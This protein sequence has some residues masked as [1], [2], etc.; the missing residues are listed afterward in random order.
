MIKSDVVNELHKPARKKFPRRRTI[1]K[2]LDDLWQIDLAEMRPYSKQNSGHN[3]I[4]VVI[5][6]FS[7]MLWTRPLK[8]KTANMVESAVKHVF[9]SSGRKPQNLQSD[10]GKEFYNAKF[11]SLMKVNN[12]NHYST[13]STT[14]AA[15]A[16][17]VIRT[18]KEKLYKK[19]S[20]QGSYNW[21]NILDQVTYEYNNTKHS[22]IKMK[23][24]NVTKKVEK[25]LLN[26]VYSHIK[27]VGKQKYKVNDVVRISKHKGVFEKGFTPNWSTELF[28]IIKVKLSNPVV[29]YLEDMENN[30]IK[31]TFYAEELQKAKHKD[32]YL[33]EKI[34]RRK[35]NKAYVKWLGFSNS[36]N[37]WIDKSNNL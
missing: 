5:D 31:G 37:S 18:L 23:P 17:R 13:F 14:K 28:K 3:Y 19:F 11:H 15:V 7:K 36:H 35:G 26:S 6:V 16:E 29:Y 33:V 1:I 2:G 34:L 22:V 24:I 10:N 9:K 27:I 8:D 21:I 25:H 32:V 4:L 20:L 30:P 12:I